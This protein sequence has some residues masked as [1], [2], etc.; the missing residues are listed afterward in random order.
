MKTANLDKLPHYTEIPSGNK[1]PLK[2]AEAENGSD[3]TGMQNLD[4]NSALIPTKKA[5]H[6]LSPWGSPADASNLSGNS[7]RSIGHLH[8]QIITRLPPR[9]ERLGDDNAARGLL[10]VKV[11][12]FVPTWSVSWEEA[13]TTSVT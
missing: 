5:S 8:G 9:I 13:H 7:V 6:P 3:K 11:H 2:I 1:N 10:N 4:S 12:V